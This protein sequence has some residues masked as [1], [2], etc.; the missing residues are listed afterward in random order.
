MLDKLYFVCVLVDDW[1]NIHHEPA[2]IFKP[3]APRCWPDPEAA[4]AFVGQ[5]YVTRGNGLVAVVMR[6]HAGYACVHSYAGSVPG[7]QITAM[8]RFMP[9]LHDLSHD[10]SRLVEKLDV[11]NLYSVGE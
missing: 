5:Y 7:E 10:A 2:V 9:L 4:Q 11:N 6:H 1:D 3:G 8:G